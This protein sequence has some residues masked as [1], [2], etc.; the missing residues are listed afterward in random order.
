[1]A[2]PDPCGGGCGANAF[3]G[4]NG[5]E[6]LAGFILEG[7]A[8]VPAAQS[9]LEART[10]EEVCGHWQAE[11]QRVSPEWEAGPN[12]GDQCDPGSVPAA[13]QANAIRRTNLYRWLVGLEPVGVDEGRLEAVQAC[14]VII[15]ALRRL[16]HNPSPNDPCFTQA[17][18]SGAGSSNIAGG[19]R[20]S[21]ADSVDLYVQDPGA[22]NIDLGHRRWVLGANMGRTA[23]G[24]KNNYSCMYSFDQS[25]R[26]AVDF[27]AWPPPG[28]VPVQAAQGLFSVAL[29]GLSPGQDFRI[30]VGADGGALMPVEIR[31]LQ[32]NY[33]RDRAS[34]SYQAPRG[35]WAPGRE[36]TV[37]LRG[38][39]NAEDVIFT[40]SFVDCR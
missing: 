16:T 28:P 32:G 20:L 33:G 1:M 19:S 14:A 5:C 24:Y 30:E 23:F 29:F 15:A 17:G 40:T 11:H 18:A 37:A 39:Q 25:N 21:M 31:R 10:A 27:I 4:D 8:C 2:P 9:P 12:P 3:C 22:S 26:Q 36:M 35:I 34:Y 7:G 13:A 38:L 6:C